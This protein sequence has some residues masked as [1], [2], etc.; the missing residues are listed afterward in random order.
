MFRPRVIP[1]LL[2]RGTG[3]VKTVKFDKYKYIGDPI[4]AVRIFNDLEADELAFVDITAT[5]EKRTVSIDL[6]KRIGDEAFMPFAVGGGITSVNDAGELLNSGAEKIII[7][8]AA[9]AN[10]GL[11]QEAANSF[12]NQSIVVS[13]DVRRNSL[14]QYEMYTHSGKNKAKVNLID[15]L[16]RM[17]NQGA[18]EILITS[19]DSDGMMSGYDIDLIKHVSATV[20]IPVIACG[21]AGTLAH[22]KEGHL[23][24]E[25]S[26]L[27]AGSMF[28]YHGPRRA[29]LINYPTSAELIA[30]FKD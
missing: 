19:I 25:A 18:G 10:P 21:G 20:S 24:G 12:G 26:A 3:L 13:V 8:T 4:N 5:L 7:N 9:V 28:V 27:A 1:L 16:K 6:V 22:F 29:V 30:T 23:R 2:L 15:H 17:E 14:N 11:I